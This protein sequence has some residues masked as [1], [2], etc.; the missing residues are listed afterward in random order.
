[1]TGSAR[2]MVRP[3]CAREMRDAAQMDRDDERHLDPPVAGVST[4]PATAD[5]GV[6][7]LLSDGTT[8]RLR[9][10][11]TGDEPRIADLF[12]GLSRDTMVMR[13]FGPHRVSDAEIDRLL[14]LDG[15]DAAA[16]LVERGGDVIALAE[17]DRQPGLSEAEVAF[18]VADQ[19]QGRGLGTLLLEHLA[20]RA[21]RAGIRRFVADTLAVNSKMLGVLR[22]AGFARQYERDAA[23]TRVVLDISP[24]EEAQQAAEDRDR[25]ATLRSIERLLRPRAIAVIGASREPGTIGHELLR[26]LV[27][28]GFSGPV[29]PVNPEA[30]SVA[31]IPAWP[32]IQSV[33]PPVDL[34]VIAVPAS[35]VLQVTEA[36]GNAGVGALV[37]I[38]AG[39]AETGP[40]GAAAQLGVTRAAHR[41]GMRLVGP[42]CFG[43]VNAEAGISMNATFA[44]NIPTGGRIGFASQSGGLGIAIL[45]EAAQ[46]GLGIS[47]FVSMGNK[48]D[49]SSNDLLTWWEDDPGTDVA[50][51]YLES[52]GNPPKFSRLARRFGRTKPIVAVKSGWSGPGTRAA[53]SHTAALA[54]PD[55]AVDA[56]FAQTGVIRVDTVEELF[57][58]GAVLANQPIPAGA[59]VGIVGNAGGPGVLA[60]DAVSGHGLAVPELSAGL[61]AALHRIVPAEAGVRNPVDMIASA[62]AV[63]YQQAIELLMAS[64]EVD[65]VIVIFTP[66][67]V[68]RANDVADAVVAA[69]G[70][71]T[72][73]GRAV[74]L[75]AAFLGAESARHRLRHAVRPV[76]CFT[77]PESAAR[78]LAHAV[79]Y[80]QW[81]AQPPSVVPELADVH[82][83]RA[84]RLLDTA[85][86][87]AIDVAAATAPVGD[88]GHTPDQA[89]VTGADAMAVLACY[90]I[91]ALPTTA[92]ASAGDAAA[93]ADEHG[94]PIAL[95]ATGPSLVHKSER[96]AVVLGLR[97]AQAVAAAYRELERR[98]GTAMTGALV[99]P[100]APAGVETIAGVVR[101]PVFGALVVFGG[102]GTSV[103]LLDDSA[104]RLMPLTEA[105]ARA[106]VLERRTSPLLTGYRGSSAVDI[107]GL[108]DL[109]LR[110]GRLAEDL[111][112][113]VTADLNPVVATTDGPVVVDAR[114]AVATHPLEP[115]AGRPRQ[116]R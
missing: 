52:F 43:V 61:Q 89:W 30:A 85:R 22:A 27:A 100:T 19:L 37:V 62:T 32:N 18:V 99:Q 38:S 70:S 46:R 11:R 20:S 10:V 44:T 69:V 26:N 39:F 3:T 5:S 4:G 81:R 113:V 97:G 115:L 55:R 16:L 71:A 90:A 8:A 109:V 63:Q 51:L 65:A 17:Y 13:F 49:V 114:I 36:C 68:T 45:S 64:G 66:P 74:P 47:S 110:L 88:D 91:P 1:M 82:P 86:S 79:R 28:G 2:R 57:D 60:A 14:D 72:A 9:P 59:R 24:S 103:E 102:G 35:A 50:L 108:V 34:A 53:T 31:S 84:R 101:D 77:Y 67:L 93:W 83:N 12:A 87:E 96:A 98:L 94:G 6:D 56:L 107:D 29:Y 105:D 104:A 33:P 54:S 41:L 80:G 95:K 40:E 42:N 7:V 78:A 21:R 58:V 48:A 15:V 112:E 106:L 116:L 76:P 111:P 92:V 23:V 73:A 75:V 25:S